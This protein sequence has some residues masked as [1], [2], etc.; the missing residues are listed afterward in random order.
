MADIIGANASI[1]EPGVG[2]GGKIQILLES[3]D[4]PANYIPIDISEEILLESAEIIK[5]RFPDVKTKPLVRDFTESITLPTLGSKGR[6]IIFFP[7][8]TI[9]NFSA[10]QAQNLLQRFAKI[11]GKDGILIIG[12]DLIKDK[13]TLEAAYD[14]ESG[15]TAEFNK[16]L[17]MRLQQELDAQL[18]LS[19][20]SHKAI[21]NADKDRIEMHLISD[22]V[23]EIKIGEYSFHFDKEETIHTENSYKYSIRSF[24]DLAKASGFSSVD[25]WQDKNNL[26]SIHC[27]KVA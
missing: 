17:L 19:E 15:I 21:Y 22:K 2:A 26:F 7:G 10:S 12:V 18:E 20:F 25:C 14:D 23:Q 5:H 1:I 4:S 9:G 8:S 3:L 13:K 16:N 27:L 11:L 6:N 24:Q